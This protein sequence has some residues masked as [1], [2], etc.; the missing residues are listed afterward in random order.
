MAILNADDLVVVDLFDTSVQAKLG[1]FQSSRERLILS[2]V[3]LLVHQ[4]AEPLRE[5]LL[6]GGWIL[7]LGFYAT[8]DI[9]SELRWFPDPGGIRPHRLAP[10]AR[11]SDLCRLIRLVD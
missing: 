2:P 8:G 7:F 5:N 11:D 6:T 3:P 1:I 4:Q 9:Y 10:D